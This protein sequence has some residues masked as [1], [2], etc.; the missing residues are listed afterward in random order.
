VLDIILEGRGDS[1]HW[2]RSI[3]RKD[4]IC[5]KIKPQRTQREHINLKNFV[6][7]PVFI[8]REVVTLP[9]KVKRR[10]GLKKWFD[11]LKTQRKERL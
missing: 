6:S 5:I 11:T 1:Q 2:K 4:H 9:W 3:S 10:V 7:S 8:D